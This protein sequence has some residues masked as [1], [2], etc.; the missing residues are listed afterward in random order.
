MKT[1]ILDSEGRVLVLG[2]QKTYGTDIVDA[3]GVEEFLTVAE[4]LVPGRQYGYREKE[5]NMA[6]TFAFKNGT[7]QKGRLLD[8][9]VYN[10]FKFR[11]KLGP[12]FVEFIFE[13]RE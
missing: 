1:I 8:V 6:K 9:A 10:G 11:E 13:G 5:A 12:V 4:T 2:E 3:M 7:V